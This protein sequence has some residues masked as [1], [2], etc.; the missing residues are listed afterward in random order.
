MTVLT[1]SANRPNFQ[2]VYSASGYPED[3]DGHRCHTL[4]GWHTANNG[5]ADETARVLIRDGDGGDII[6]DIQLH[7]TESIGESFHVMNCYRFPNGLYIDVLEGTVR[8]SIRGR[9]S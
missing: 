9:T 1:P 6:L 4:L 2:Q 8:G 5:G 3:E 7:D